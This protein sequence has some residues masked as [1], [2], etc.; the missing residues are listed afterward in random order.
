[1][2]TS[3]RTTTRQRKHSS[4]LYWSEAGLW[5]PADGQRVAL[6]DLDGT[7]M[8]SEAGREEAWNRAL[9]EL[10][11]LIPTDSVSRLNAYRAVYKCH[12]DIT[13]K[14]GPRGYEF[15]DFRQ[16]WNTHSSYAVL[17]AWYELYG[18]PARGDDYQA[19]LESL[20]RDQT[21]G[22]A[23]LAEAET[24]RDPWSIEYSVPIERAVS[25]FWAGNWKKHLCPGVKKLL[26]SLHRADIRYYVATEGHVPTQWQ[27]I[28][29]VGLNDIDQVLKKPLIKQEQLLATSQ[30]AQPRGEVDAMDSLIRWYHGRAAACRGAADRLQDGLQQQRKTLRDDA[31]ASDLV[32]NGLN[33]ISGLFDRL[34]EKLHDEGGTKWAFYVRTMYAINRDLEHPRS[35]FLTFRLNWKPGTKIR[36]AMVG[37]SHKSDIQPLVEYSQTAGAK[38]L[39]IW[40]R[41]QGHG[42]KEP[43]GGGSRDVRWLESD[44]IVSAGRDFL[45]NAECWRKYTEPL[46]QPIGLFGSAVDPEQKKREGQQEERLANNLDELIAGI[47]AVWGER[48]VKEPLSPEPD[49]VLTLRKLMDDEWFKIIVADIRS[50]RFKQDVQ[51]TLSSLCFNPFLRR[52]KPL[53]LCQGANYAALELL[54]SI[55]AAD[56]GTF[57]NPELLDSVATLL[58][59]ADKRWAAVAIYALDRR[60]NIEQQ[61]A[62]AGLLDKYLSRL[63]ALRASE[64][65]PDW[66]P[67]DRLFFLY[68]RLLEERRGTSGAVLVAPQP[69]PTSPVG[70]VDTLGQSSGMADLQ[71][72]VRLGES[73]AKRGV[74]CNIGGPKARN[75]ICVCGEEG[76]GKFSTLT[77]LVRGCL[78]GQGLPNVTAPRSSV[79]VFNNDPSGVDRLVDFG[80]GSGFD[81]SVVVLDREVALTK[82]RLSGKNVKVSPLRFSLGQLGD[83][84]ILQWLGYDEKRIP[85]ELSAILRRV[86]QA[87]TNEMNLDELINQVSKAHFRDRDSVQAALEGMRP[88][89]SN[90]SFLDELAGGRLTIL[91]CGRTS[92]MSKTDTIALWNRVLTVLADASRERRDDE[93]YLLVFDELAQVFGSKPTS[94]ERQ[95]GKTLEHI[96]SLG[97]H[98]HISML[99]ISQTPEELLRIAALATHATILLFH[100]VRRFPPSIPELPLWDVAR[101][102]KTT[103]STL[104]KGEVWYA[105]TEGGETTGRVQ[106]SRSSAARA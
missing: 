38:I 61:I 98:L 73:N 70:Q 15:E 25:S 100:R 45:L 16:Q 28:S 101:R 20:L 96:A 65:V 106:I 93:H 10:R 13:G 85:H 2:A 78:S 7:L 37:D 81:V 64:E 6:L 41:R 69:P 35:Q 24:I 18:F 51:N 50:G 34:A 42:D 56:D 75:I 27:K 47:G 95:L 103:F 36:L 87:Q 80:L 88:F 39:S 46:R 57:R 91:D 97:R 58:D 29:H 94:D 31:N 89:L 60:A 76:I 63:E 52:N 26:R 66:F 54:L 79:I 92:K 72:S 104:A 83:E 1:M 90:E 33:R 48:Y 67:D 84:T 77:T 44:V 74:W 53:F 102:V 23:L 62:K 12:P 99:G 86:R 59:T 30:A 11:G 4:R 3:N 22:P 32:A 5:N 9:S 55:M 17:I 82:E 105:S 49:I 40:L 14:R 8:D 68:Q 71:Q 19:E 21:K 43:D